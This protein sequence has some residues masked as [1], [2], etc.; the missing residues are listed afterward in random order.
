MPLSR[1]DYEFQMWGLEDELENAKVDGAQ[2]VKELK[3][4]HREAV[5][6]LKTKHK[7]TIK[8]I[9]TTHEQL[10]SEKKSKLKYAKDE[11]EE[12]MRQI[13]ELEK[14][15]AD[16][17]LIKVLE[18]SEHLLSDKRGELQLLTTR[19]NSMRETVSKLEKEFQQ[20]ESAKSSIQASLASVNEDYTQRVEE[21]ES[22][23]LIIHRE[24][25]LKIP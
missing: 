21:V 3:A 6:D 20:S 19:F 15:V 2:K 24:N 16:D 25:N 11:R 9:T 17:E 13:K 12:I 7:E 5:E 10:L 1:Y 8:S 18:K 22:L 23:I 4:K 14:I